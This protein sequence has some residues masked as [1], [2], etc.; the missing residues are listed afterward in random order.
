MLNIPRAPQ[1]DFI[2]LLYAFRFYDLVDP[3]PGFIQVVVKMGFRAG[4]L[5]TLIAE[6]NPFFL[7]TGT[8]PTVFKQLTLLVAASMA[9]F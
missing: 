3:H 9:V 6:I 1:S 4:E 5:I 2:I 8:Y 7:V